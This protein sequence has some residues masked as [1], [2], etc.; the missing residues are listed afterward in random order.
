MRI[1]PQLADR[2][3]AMP[4]AELHVHVEGATNA[5]TFYQMAKRNRVDLPANSLEEWQSFFEFRDFPHFIQVYSAG[6]QL[7]A[8]ARRLCAHAGKSLQ[9]TISGKH[10]LY[11]SIYQCIVSDSE[12]HSDEDILAAIAAGCAAGKTKYPCRINLISDISRQIPDS[13]HRVLELTLKGKERGIFL[14]LGLGGLEVG[15]PPELF[16]DT[17]AEAHRQGLRVV[18]HAGEAV[19]AQSIW[20]AVNSLQVERI[21]HGIRCLEDA[22]LVDVLRQRQIPLEVSPQSNY[23]LGVVDQDQ[24]SSNPSDG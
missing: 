19:G 17:F 20:G 22:K 5:E 12:V 9:A 23:C 11:R 4:K 18:A 6:G 15:Y 2:L 8:N 3:R 24:P 10:P 21:G 1:S 13:Q 14:G 16:T 7:F